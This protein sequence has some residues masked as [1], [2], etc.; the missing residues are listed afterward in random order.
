MEKKQIYLV[1]VLFLFF[2]KY[3]SKP[4][5]VGEKVAHAVISAVHMLYPEGAGCPKSIIGAI[6]KEWVAKF[7][8]GLMRVLLDKKE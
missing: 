2:D 5:A 6:R 1:N 7:T 3:V 4:E 8:V